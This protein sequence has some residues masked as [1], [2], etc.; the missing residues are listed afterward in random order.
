[1]KDDKTVGCDSEAGEPLIKYLF[2]NST[3]MEFYILLL[4]RQ[5]N[6]Q[7]KIV[8]CVKVWAWAAVVVLA[9]VCVGQ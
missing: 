3:R 9:R 6:I 1:M 7:R 4:Q 2:S 5:W 8:E